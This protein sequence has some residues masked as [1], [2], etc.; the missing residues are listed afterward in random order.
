MA[1]AAAPAAFAETLARHL[2]EGETASIAVQEACTVQESLIRAVWGQADA[3][4][5]T[6]AVCDAVRAAGV[7]SLSMWDCKAAAVRALHGEPIKAAG[8][9][10]RG[11]A[12][13]WMGELRRGA[14]DSTSDSWRTSAVALLRGSMAL[15]EAASRAALMSGDISLVG[16]ALNADLGGPIGASLG[17]PALRPAD[18][19]NAALSAEDPSGGSSRMTAAG[20]LAAAAADLPSRQDTRLRAW[21][22]LAAAC[23]AAPDSVGPRGLAVMLRRSGHPSVRGNA[24]VLQGA[25][26]AVW[27]AVRAVAASRPGAAAPGA[28]PAAPHTPRTNSGAAPS[29]PVAASLH[30]SK[31]GRAEAEAAPSDTPPAA[32]AA[33]ASPSAAGPVVDASQMGP[34]LRAHARHLA[35]TAAPHLG[36]CH[37]EAGGSAAAASAAFHARGLASASIA[38]AAAALAVL[39]LPIEHSE[40]RTSLGAA[41]RS[42]SNPPD[43]GDEHGDDSAPPGLI[44][45][46][47][48]MQVAFG[49]VLE[50]QD[51]ATALAEIALLG[52]QQDARLVCPSRSPKRPVN[53]NGEDVLDAA[54]FLFSGGSRRA[55]RPRLRG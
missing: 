39:R 27:T 32:A 4:V 3:E 46:R 55:L 21:R 19:I 47:S 48:V 52:R 34:L 8:R 20:A 2:A 36:A 50:L 25:C 24:A 10:L 9:A 54:S 1:A 6:G 53:E 44:A 14:A 23:A 28:A 42:I 31:C 41:I 7:C 49:G 17:G 30:A 12:A 40:D 33:S 43:L 13:R 22:C 16:A 5:A 45:A 38:V 51:A 15:V 11:L 29:N 26:V 35:L 18:A 37:R